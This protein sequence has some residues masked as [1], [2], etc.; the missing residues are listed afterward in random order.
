MKKSQASIEFII[1]VSILLLIAT[2]VVATW[3][4]LRTVA[5]DKKVENLA[6]ENMRLVV[7]HIN[8]AQK[9]GDGYIGRFFLS[10]SLLSINYNITVSDFYVATSWQSRTIISTINVKDVT[11]EIQTGWNTVRNVGGTIFVN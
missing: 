2:V 3:W 5:F 7:L 6:G 11:G 8:S 9:I 4:P 10:P 1:Y